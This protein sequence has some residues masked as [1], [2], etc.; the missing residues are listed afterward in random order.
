[1]TT[2]KLAGMV[3]TVKNLPYFGFENLATLVETFYLQSDHYMGVRG[4]SPI[5]VRHQSLV[6]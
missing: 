5:V 3:A 1:V 2:D 6:I 4:T